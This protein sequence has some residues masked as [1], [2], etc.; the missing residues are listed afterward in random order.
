VV[1]SRN[2]LYTARIAHATALIENETLSSEINSSLTSTD[3]PS[4]GAAGKTIYAERLRSEEAQAADRTSQIIAQADKLR[5]E[6]DT[7]RRDIADRKNR[8]TRRKTDLAEASSGIES[9]RSRH[10]EE[11]ERAIQMTKYKWNRSFESMAAT[12]SYLCME[13]ARLYGLHRIKRG[14]SM[15]FELGGVEM[16]ELPGMISGYL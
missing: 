15:R 13:A 2:R 3:R 5:A 9:R 16:I 10:M 8:N 14:N 1:D 11:A 4:S 6:I 12:R 7:A